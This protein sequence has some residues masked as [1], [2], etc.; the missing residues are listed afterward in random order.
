MW[1]RI[2]F[3][4]RI[5]I[6]YIILGAL[7]I[8]FSDQLLLWFT[9]DPYQIQRFSM[10]KGWFYVL[11]TG[12]LLFF[13]VRR[14]IRR[15][16]QLYND[17]LEAK[18]KAEEASRL[19]TAFLSNLSHY[20]RTPMNGILGFIELL[21]DKD[22]SEAT[23]RLFMSYIHESSESL[24]QTLTSIIEIAMIQ[25]GQ[26]TVKNDTIHVNK[27]I[28]RVAAKTRVDLSAAKNPVEVI[29]RNS[30]QDG[31][32]I[33]YSDP[34]RLL[35]ILSSLAS[36]AVR[37]TNRGEVE[38]GYD[39][40]ERTVRFWVRDTRPGIPEQKRGTLFNSF[41]QQNYTTSLK[42]EG[43]GLGLALASGLTGLLNGKLWLEKSGPDGTTFC[44][45]IPI[46]PGDQPTIK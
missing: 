37:F 14:E 38:I 28:E 5:T 16:R 1:K 12:I 43:A 9:Q 42:G 30:W 21:E 19:K 40:E 18:R 33:I 2:P 6:L 7:W 27:L 31:D 35:L 45:T 23:Q 11:I 15:Q 8:M 4:Y 44:L 26:A 29:I 34:D 46:I 3:Q 25:E 24:L 39:A 22:N 17:L 10:Y 41:L 20:I 36:N 13:L 32:D